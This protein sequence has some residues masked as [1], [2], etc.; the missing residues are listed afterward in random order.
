MNTTCDR[1]EPPDSGLVARPPVRKPEPAAAPPVQADT[2]RP[3]PACRAPTA[4]SATAGSSSTSREPPATLGF[5]HGY[6]LAR[7]PPS[8]SASSRRS[9]RTR[10]S[11]T[12]PSTAQASEQMLW[13]K[14]D[15]EYQQEIDGIVA[16]LAREGREGGS[17]G[18]G[19]AQRDR[20]TRRVLRALARQAAGQAADDQG[21]GQLQRVRGD[22]HA[23]R[24]T[25][26]RS[27]ATTTGRTTSSARAG[28]SSSTCTPE[29]GHRILMDGLP[30]VI[31]SDDDF[32]INSNGIM[33]TETTITGFEGFD[34]NGKP[35][36]V[37]ARKAMQYSSSIDDYVRIMLDGNNGAYANDWLIA[38]NK[39]GEIARFELGLKEHSRRAHEGRLLRRRQLPGRREADQGRDDVRSEE[40]GQLAQRPARPLGA[41]DGAAQGAD[42]RRAGEGSSRPTST[43]SSRSRTAR[44]SDRSAA[45]S[46]ARRAA[47]PSG[48]GRPT[49]RAAPCR[50]RW[51][52]RRWPRRCRCGR[53][54][55][56]RARRTSRPTTFLA[57][58]AGVRLDA[59][60]CCRT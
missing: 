51:R 32:G 55:A 29:K 25:A 60:A 59:R 57:A 17:L 27:S 28:T 33:I 9:R 58:H 49:S 35:E 41:V 23:T 38:D 2:G 11:A 44:T 26:S 56:I 42:R 31:A 4:S 15:A 40:A 34:P 30:G 48:T 39:T 7:K 53:R 12:G 16:G 5:Q 1:L 13:P 37:R 43:T 52:T 6:L 8:C 10:P 54:W 3:T 21:A 22:R 24:R 46:T 18:R 45:T 14:M 36:F 47:S 19:G 20:G 50:R